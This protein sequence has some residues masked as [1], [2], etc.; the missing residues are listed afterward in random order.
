M[1]KIEFANR[2]L[3]IF[4]IILF[5][6]VNTFQTL[7][8]EFLVWLYR[9]WCHETVF[10]NLYQTVKMDKNLTERIME[11]NYICRRFPRLIFRLILSHLSKKSSRNLFQTLSS[12]IFR[13]M[14]RWQP[15]FRE[16]SFATNTWV[17]QKKELTLFLMGIYYVPTIC[18]WLLNRTKKN[19]A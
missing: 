17:V 7:S 16:G 9:S 11:W 14:N 1:H 13:D 2:S 8:K 18:P 19:R 5:S 12:W 6:Y 3:T 4:G 10:A 15:S